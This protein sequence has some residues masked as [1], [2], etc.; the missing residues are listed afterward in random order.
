MRTLILIEDITVYNADGLFARRFD[1]G[2]T[3]HGKYD[4]LLG[5]F[6]CTED[7]ITFMVYRDECVP[8]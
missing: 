1:T 8:C 6:V 4:P 2:L 7:G 5:A 3:V